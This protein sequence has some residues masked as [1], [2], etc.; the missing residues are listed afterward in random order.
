MTSLPP[1]RIIPRPQPVRPSGIGSGAVTGV[2]SQ[3]APLE[4]EKWRCFVP[5]CAAEVHFPPHRVA[6]APER[7]RSGKQ[8][9]CCEDH[10]REL[11]KLTGLE[12]LPFAAVPAGLVLTRCR[13]CGFEAHYSV[14]YL[15][16]R[17]GADEAVCRACYWNERACTLMSRGGGAAEQPLRIRATAA[18]HGFQYIGPLGPVGAEFLPNFPHAVMCAH[19]GKIAAKRSQDLKFRCPCATRNRCKKQK[20]GGS[21]AKDEPGMLRTA[22]ATARPGVDPGVR[23]RHHPAATSIAQVPEQ[24]FEVIAGSGPLD[25]GAR[26]CGPGAAAVSPDEQAEASPIGAPVVAWVAAAG[27]GATLTLTPS[28]LAS[29]EIT[30]ADVVDFARAIKALLSQGHSLTLAV[31]RHTRNC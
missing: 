10:A 17:A 23:V 22:D 9:G 26:A 31:E 13:S 19:C 21:V 7:G 14:D 5:D 12:L 20:T 1:A 11:T 3:G 29:N 27:P 2:R 18:A 30:E 4:A 24:P 28:S 8:R 6:V 25:E 16:G 15:S